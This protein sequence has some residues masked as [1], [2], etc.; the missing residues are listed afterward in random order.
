M[1]VRPLVQPAA[2]PVDRQPEFKRLPDLPLDRLEQKSA[3]RVNAHPVFPKVKLLADSLGQLYEQVERLEL[4]FQTYR[5]LRL[6]QERLYEAYD[7]LT[8][9][10]SSLFEAGNYPQRQALLPFD[11]ALSFRNA[12]SLKR[13]QRDVYIEEAYQ[14]LSDLL[15]QP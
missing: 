11:E 8:E 4:D 3:A 15:G 14:I 9:R 7:E 1:D 12:R 6:K 13:I 5:K 10:E 2:T